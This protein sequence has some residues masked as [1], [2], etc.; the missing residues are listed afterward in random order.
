[1]NRSPKMGENFPT[2]WPWDGTSVM[3]LCSNWNTSLTAETLLQLCNLIH[4][5]RVK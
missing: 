5:S 2:F 1:M 3:A 4:E